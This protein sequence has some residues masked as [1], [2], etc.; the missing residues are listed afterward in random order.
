MFGTPIVKIKF[1]LLN[2]LLVSI[3]YTSMVD[4]KMDDITFK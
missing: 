3:F 4:N 1:T 2:L